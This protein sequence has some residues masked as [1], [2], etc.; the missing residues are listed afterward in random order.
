MS[1]R[2]RVHIPGPPWMKSSSHL[3]VIQ[4]CE[5]TLQRQIEQFQVLR[6]IHSG[7]TLSSVLTRVNDTFQLSV[8]IN[9]GVQTLATTLDTK[10]EELKEIIHSGRTRQNQNAEVTPRTLNF[11]GRDD[12][13][14]EVVSNLVAGR[15]VC[16]FG[17]EGIGRTSTAAQI[18]NNPHITSIFADIRYWI[19]CSRADT[20]SKFEDLLCTQILGSTKLGNANRMTGLQLFLSST[21]KRKLILLDDFETTWNVNED[22]CKTALITLSQ[23]TDVTLL[24]TMNSDQLPKGFDP[25]TFFRWFDE[26]IGGTVSPSSN[27]TSV[28]SSLLSSWVPSIIPPLE[29]DAAANLFGSYFALTYPLSA[30]E[31]ESLDALLK[32]LGGRPS[33]IKLV[34]IRAVNSAT[35]AIQSMVQ[36][37]SGTDDPMTFIIKD[38]VDRLER[39]PNYQRILNTLALFPTGLDEKQLDIWLSFRNSEAMGYLCGIC[40]VS[41]NN[42]TRRWS[43]SPIIRSRLSPTDPAAIVAQREAYKMTLNILQRNADVTKGPM[44]PSFKTHMAELASYEPG[45]NELV[46][47]MISCLNSFP[48]FLRELKEEGEKDRDASKDRVIN[49]LHAYINYQ[50]WSRDNKELTLATISLAKTWKSQKLPWLHYSLGITLLQLDQYDAARKE[51]DLASEGFSSQNDHFGLVCSTTQGIKARFT[52]GSEDYRYLMT[53]LDELAARPTFHLPS[54]CVEPGPGK[55]AIQR[56]WREG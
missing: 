41:F 47:S 15:H 2:S 36:E 53:L 11:I 48:D 42:N 5:V 50:S 1:I 10:L 56:K 55:R 44:H 24:L 6:T 8:E 7:K 38:S 40:L 43:L 46:L 19:P 54:L 27:P 32:K 9:K 39:I 45:L 33:L 28:T 12:F 30:S 14:N 16:M 4:E 31:S 20:F 23:K 21:N 17:E 13:V 25:K 51:F 34:A 3:G 37:L 49:S 35:P 52:L 26:P 22:D 18:I 29:R